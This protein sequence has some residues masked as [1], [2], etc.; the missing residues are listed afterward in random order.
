MKLN[1]KKMYIYSEVLMLIIIISMIFLTMPKETY[2]KTQI[3]AIDQYNNIVST[4][5]VD[6]LEAWSLGFRTPGDIQQCNNI[7]QPHLRMG[8]MGFKGVQN[9]LS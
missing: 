5:E 3:F 8:C 1:K 9:G 2:A 7:T 4:I 6:N